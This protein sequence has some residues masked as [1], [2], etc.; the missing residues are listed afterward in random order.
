MEITDIKL[1]EGFEAKFEGKTLVVVKADEKLDTWEKC[2]RYL[3]R[4]EYI[5]SVSHAVKLDID[6][7]Y[8][9]DAADHNCIPI[10]TGDKLLALMQLLICREAYYRHYNCHVS[11]DTGPV[12][13]IFR[14]SGNAIMKGYTYGDYRPI[15]SFS[16]EQARNDFFSAFHGLIEQAG[17]LV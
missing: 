15:L 1:P 2:M 7:G 6:P 17:D 10:G 13:Y 4:A 9:M 14:S 16:K 8:E 5:D 3:G 12:Y 11:L